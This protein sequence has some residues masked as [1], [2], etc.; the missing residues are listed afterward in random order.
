MDAILDHPE[1]AE[2]RHFE[3]YCLDSMIPFY[4][5][6]GFRAGIEGLNFMR[7]G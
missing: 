4:E 3:L 5:K 1:L 6:W 7:R 2:V